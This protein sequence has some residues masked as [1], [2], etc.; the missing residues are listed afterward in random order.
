MKL[1]SNPSTRRCSLLPGKDAIVPAGSNVMTIE[2]MLFHLLKSSDTGHK[3]Y[4]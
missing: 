3:I 4:F 2:R 1:R